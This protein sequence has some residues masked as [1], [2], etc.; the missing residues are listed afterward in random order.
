MYQEV[1]VIGSLRDA[2]KLEW[3]Y[4]REIGDGMAA[5]EGH[6]SF[7]SQNSVVHLHF[8]SPLIVF[9]GPNAA[10]D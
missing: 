7:H 5:I 9:S 1:N 3:T 6:G 10:A 8:V 2:C 4:K